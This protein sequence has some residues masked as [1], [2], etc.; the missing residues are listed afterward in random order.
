MRILTRTDIQSLTLI[1]ISINITNYVSL[2]RSNEAF[3][4]IVYETKVFQSVKIYHLR[5]V[6]LF[7]SDVENVQ[8]LEALTFLMG[9]IRKWPSKATPTTVCTADIHFLT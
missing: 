6:L 3:W 5:L 4:R 2:Y 9:E 1:A 8:N 7:Y